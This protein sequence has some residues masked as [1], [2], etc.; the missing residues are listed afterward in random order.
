M[1][2]RRPDQRQ[3]GTSRAGVGPAPSASVLLA[4]VVITSGPGEGVYNYSGTP[5]LGNPPVTSDSNGITD[6]YGNTIL[7]GQVTYSW[8][9]SP[10]YALQNNGGTLIFWYWTGSAFTEEAQLGLA[11]DVGTSAVS[12]RLNVL[13]N[14]AVQIS[15]YAFTLFGGLIIGVPSG[16][17]SGTT[18]Y[19]TLIDA[20]GLLTYGGAVQMLSGASTWQII[21][22]IVLPPHVRLAGVQWMEEDTSPFCLQPVSGFLGTSVISLIS[23]AAGGYATESTGQSV[24]DINIDGTLLGGYSAGTVDAVNATGLVHDVTLERVTMYNI[25]GHGLHGVTDSTGNPH[26]WRIS[27][28]TANT[29]GDAGFAPG[30][31][32]DST[33]IDPKAIN[34]GN[35]AFASGF[36]ISG[37]TNSHFIGPRAEFNNL[38]G[39]QLSGA[40][41][42]GTG[43]GPQV[44]DGLSTD[45][46]Q[47]HGVYIDATGTIPIVLNGPQLRR[48]ASAS[49][50]GGAGILIDAATTCPVIM[51]DV[52][53]FPGVNDDGSGTETPEYGI[54][55]IGT[56]YT[57]INGA[58]LHAVTAGLNGTPTASRDVAVRAG[59]TAT[60]GAISSLPDYLNAAWNYVGAA[61]EPAFGTGWSNRG[62]PWAAVAFRLIN[63]DCVQVKGWASVAVVADITLFTLPAGYQPASSQTV[64]AWSVTAGAPVQFNVA[65][66]TG[67]IGAAPAVL[68][69]AG[70]YWFDTE[71][72]LSL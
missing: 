22:S 66:G 58:Y 67:V 56:G 61:G 9:T 10:P 8:G 20:I 42:S 63:S 28:V 57:E 41:G 14:N 4:R 17:T 5:R 55:I 25:G 7:P 59:T 2:P 62:S 39:F 6:P 15:D 46:N 16:D 60:P 38:Y 53:V 32:T 21:N 71:I 68:P 54:N 52:T 36:F 29:T 13:S 40:V 72:S 23:Q 44:F 26:T 11:A 70:N 51:N 45:R 43:S 48:D 31:L 24:V 27:H 12:I 49:P 30:Q 37:C 50:A 35:R 33:W 65:A 18:D 64:Q 69:A 34:C 19:D 1:I 3:T 47:L